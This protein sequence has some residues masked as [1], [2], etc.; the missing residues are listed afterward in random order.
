MPNLRGPQQTNLDA[1]DDGVKYVDDYIG[2]LMDELDRRGLTKNTLVIIT[3]GS[4]GIAGTAP[5]CEL[6]AKRSTGS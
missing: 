1:Y 2:R 3:G 5:S 6:T 4:R